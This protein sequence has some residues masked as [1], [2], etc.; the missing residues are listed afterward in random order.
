MTI[1]VS[2]ALGGPAAAMAAEKSVTGEPN[3]PAAQ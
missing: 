2:R 3:R 1:P